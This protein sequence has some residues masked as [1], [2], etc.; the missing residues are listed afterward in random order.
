MIEEWRRNLENDNVVGAVLMD[1]S[2]AFNC[3]PHDLLIAKLPAYGF[4][5]NAL[6]YIYSYLK[7]RQ[8]SVRINNTYSTFQLVLSGVP[9]GS[10]PG[11]ILFNSYIN[12]LYL[13]VKK[14]T[15]HNYADDNT[16]TAFSNLVPNLLRIME[17]ESNVAID[18]LE[19]NQMIANPDKV[20][21]VFVTKGRDDTTG[22]KL[23]I[24]GKQSQS[25]NAVRLLGVK[26]DHRLNF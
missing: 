4:H 1:L 26:I 14:A 19:R 25:E 20:H 2:N 12:D 18:W 24:Q 17:Q 3:I 15:L 23:M 16:L 22:E 10:V 7:R 6:V 11:P 5:E 21:A 13:Y 8:Q 9:Q